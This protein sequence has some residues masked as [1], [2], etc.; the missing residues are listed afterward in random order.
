MLNPLSC[1]DWCAHLSA[2]FFGVTRMGQTG[3]FNE[4]IIAIG[5]DTSKLSDTNITLVSADGKRT[6]VCAARTG[7]SR[8]SRV[9]IAT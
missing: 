9:P 7:F 2:R 8:Q 6:E 4:H 1:S 3:G 5:H